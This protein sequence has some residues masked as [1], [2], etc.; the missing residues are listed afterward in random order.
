MNPTTLPTAPFDRAT[1]LSLLHEVPILASL[2]EE[3]LHCLDDVEQI[4]LAAGTLF[5]RQGEAARYFYVV[6]TGSIRIFFHKPDGAEV[7]AVTLPAGNAIGELPLLAGIQN[8]TSM[9]T[10]EPSLLLRFSEDEFWSL[11]TT[12]PMVRKAIL[13]NMAFRLQRFQSHTL[14]QEKMASLGTLAAGLMHELNNPGAAARRAASQLRENLLRLHELAAKFTYLDLSHSQKQCLI[15]LQTQALAVKAP[16]QLNSLEQSDAEEA[17]AEWMENANIANAWKLAPTL[18]SIGFHPG[19]LD[20]ARSSFTGEIFS[21]A[22]SWL[23]ALVSSMQLVGTIEESIGRVSTLVAAVKSYAYEGKGQRQTLNVN[24]SIYATLVILGHKIR[25][26]QLILEK[27]LDQ[28]L[29]PLESSCSGLNQVWTNILDNAIDALPEQGHIRL[30][31]WSEKHATGTVDLCIT[32]ED[33]GPGIPL[34]SQ[35]HIFDPFYTT[36]PVGVGTGLGL[37]IAHRIVEQYGGTIRFTSGP[38][39]TIFYVRLPAKP[40]TP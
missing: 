6:L 16:I 26:K 29:P 28:D 19:E 38:G 36:K 30:K 31:T 40:P 27:K 39:S 33:D 23:E 4:H 21:D 8:P 1:L 20:C 18:V 3:D 35:P 24:E 25:E 13:G 17:L 10:V 12:C 7:T 37:G 15:D 5:E 34:D 9:E 2:S 11:M 32:I 22:L 14:Q